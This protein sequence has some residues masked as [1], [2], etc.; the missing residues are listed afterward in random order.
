MHHS[1]CADV[2]APRSVCSSGFPYTSIACMETSTILQQRDELIT[3]IEWTKL[4]NVSR[5]FDLQSKVRLSNSDL[6]SV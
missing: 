1:F 5:K 3:A 6:D 2:N 4:V